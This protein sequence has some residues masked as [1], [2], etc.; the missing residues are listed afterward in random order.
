MCLGCGK[1]N[2][3]SF[4]TQVRNCPNQNVEIILEQ[5]QRSIATVTQYAP[6]LT[7]VVIVV[8]TQASAIILRR[9]GAN[10]ALV[11]RG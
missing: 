5:P 4:V 2:L 11:Q 9:S 8:Y 3:G 7:C 6:Y 1:I 10:L